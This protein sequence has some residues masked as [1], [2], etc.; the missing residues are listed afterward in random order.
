MQKLN[1]SD[2]REK[3]AA[4]RD[5]KT[6]RKPSP[7][8]MHARQLLANADMLATNLGIPQNI[9]Q[10]TNEDLQRW[11]KQSLGAVPVET[12]VNEDRGQY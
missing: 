4:N 10:S 12:I 7:A 2:K 3:S 8:I 11:G 6:L 5:T 1:N 9:K